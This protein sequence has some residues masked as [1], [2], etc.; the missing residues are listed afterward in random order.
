LDE[1]AWVRLGRLNA[2]RSR[3]TTDFIASHPQDYALAYLPAYAPELNPEEQCNALVKG[4]MANAL[5]G[6]VDDPASPRP[7]RVQP[8]EAPP[9]IDRPLLP[10]CRSLRYRDHVKII[11]NLTLPLNGALSTHIG[12]VPGVIAAKDV[13]AKTFD[14]E[15]FNGFGELTIFPP[16]LEPQF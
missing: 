13:A 6:S 8:A 5:P 16:Q 11:S 15:F 9:R 2:H 1:K 4:A 10:S 12:P 3:A 14:A 7:P